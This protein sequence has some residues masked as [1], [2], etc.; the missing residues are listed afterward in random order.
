MILDRGLNEILYIRAKITAFDAA[1]QDVFVLF[2]L[3]VMSAHPG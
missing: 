3:F 1:P 2:F